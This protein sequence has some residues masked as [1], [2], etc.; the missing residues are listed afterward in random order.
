[1]APKRKRIVRYPSDEV[2]GEGSW[3]LVA[4]LTVAEMREVRKQ[5][6]AKDADLFELGVALMKSHVKE[7][8]WVDDEGEPLPFPKDQPEIIEDLSDPESAFLSDRIRGSDAETK[9]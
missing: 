6:K 7:W 9:N 3:V 5:Q 4:R 2:Q 1:M 8:N